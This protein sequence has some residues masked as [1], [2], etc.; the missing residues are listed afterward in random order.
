MIF[1]KQDVKKKHQKY[2]E[3]KEN[4][5]VMHLDYQLPVQI[6]LSK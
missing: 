6:G 5:I 1:I 2:I 4:A 3:N